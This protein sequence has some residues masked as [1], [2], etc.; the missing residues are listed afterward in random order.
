[1]EDTVAAPSPYQRLLAIYREMPEPGE[2]E[3]AYRVPVDPDTGPSAGVTDEPEHGRVTHPRSLKWAKLFNLRYRLLLAYLAHFL[4]TDGALLEDNADYTPRGLLNKWTFDEM[5]HLSDVAGKLVTL[6]RLEGEPEQ[7][8]RAGPPF[9]LPYT[10]NL[11]DL[12]RDRWRTHLDV[13]GTSLALEESIAAQ[14]PEDAEDVL[15]QDL[16][17]SD[18]DAQ[19]LVRAAMSGEPL[20]YAERGFGKVVRL[21]EESVRG[22]SIG[23]HRN[24]WRGCTRDQFVSMEVFGQQLIAVRPDGSFD[25][26]GS[27]LIKALRG[28][29]PFDA[30]ATG[31]HDPTRYPRM[32]AHHPPMAP[33]GIEYI[34]RWI[35]AGCPE[36]E[37]PG[38]VG[39]AGEK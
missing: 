14:H 5:R 16:I 26:A 24:F 19:R 37:P 27:N 1:V 10:L 4:M 32:P 11:P 30:P 7:P 21:L 13:L 12:E 33:Q 18:R 35:E 8:E 31:E 9:E 36:S 22:F 15:L 2:W 23:A 28:E 6:P 39:M 38:Q 3:P 29:A 20:T 25:A 34:Y 17:R